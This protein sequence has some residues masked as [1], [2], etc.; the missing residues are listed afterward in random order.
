LYNHWETPNG[1]VDS[2][3]ALQKKHGKQKIVSGSYAVK[4]NADSI[5]AVDVSG[6]M[7]DGTVNVNVDN[8]QKDR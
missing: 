6:N 7:K 8:T 5:G 1:A 4:Y 3:V 2:N